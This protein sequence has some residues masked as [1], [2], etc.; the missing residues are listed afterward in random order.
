MNE[1]ERPYLTVTEIA[2]RWC[3]NLT[4]VRRAIDSRHKPLLG[5]KSPPDNAYGQGTWLIDVQ[6]VINRWGSPRR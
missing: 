2:Y 4:S 5:Y 1:N 3:K 6:S